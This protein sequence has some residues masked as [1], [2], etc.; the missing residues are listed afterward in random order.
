MSGRNGKW[1]VRG[2]PVT[3]ADSASVSSA[4]REKVF[5]G[6]SSD[7]QTVI[8]GLDARTE[9]RV[10]VRISDTDSVLSTCFAPLTAV[11]VRCSPWALRV[12]VYLRGSEARPREAKR[13][14]A[15]PRAV[16]RDAEG[17]LGRRSIGPFARPQRCEESAST[18]AGGSKFTLGAFARQRRGRPRRRGWRRARSAA[19]S[20]VHRQLGAMDGSVTSLSRS[21]DT[22]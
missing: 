10:S 3:Y 19:G 7:C 21:R 12:L 15:E 14:C 17:I 18:Q 13:V 8:E 1:S 2:G 20:A 5:R 9:K 4:F 11:L 22:S 16:P 6:E